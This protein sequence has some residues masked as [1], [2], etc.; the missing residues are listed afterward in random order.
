[1]C[2]HE[3]LQKQIEDIRQSYTDATKGETAAK[4]EK[5]AEL[6]A[7]QK[8]QDGKIL[9]LADKF[10]VIQK[11]L[12]SRTDTS[13]THALLREALETLRQ[14]AETLEHQ[15]ELSRSGPDIA[16]ELV[17]ESS[18]EKLPFQRTSH[19]ST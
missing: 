9:E 6:L 2:T 12:E 11:E 10:A 7:C 17:R 18:Q 4:L 1:M 14:H 5:L 8:H 19:Q 13:T 15:I 3:T 16:T